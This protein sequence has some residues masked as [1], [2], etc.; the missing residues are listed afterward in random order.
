MRVFSR[1]ALVLG[2]A[3]ISASAALGQ[4]NVAS[5]PVTLVAQ[6]AP[7]T[8]FYKSPHGIFRFGSLVFELRGQ[9]LTT[10]TVTDLGDMQVA[11]EDFV[12]SMAARESNGGTAF[13]NGFLYVSSEAGIEIFDLRGVRPGGNAPLLVSR[14]PNVH[15]RRLAVSGNMLAA[16]FPATDYPCFVNGTA[17]C[18]NVID[19]YNVSNPAAPV[20]VGSISSQFPSQITS[21]NDITFNFGI[22]FATGFNG[23]IGYNLTNPAAAG[24]ITFV[25]TPGT[26]LVSNGTN[27]LGIGSDRQILTYTVI[28]PGTGSFFVLVPLTLHTVAPIDFERANRLV[29][30]PQ[31]NIDEQSLRLVTMIDELDPQTLKPA[32]TI[33]FDV[34]DYGVF[35]YEG[36]LPRV[37][38]QI[39]YLPTNDEVKYNPL[40]VGPLVYVVGELSGLQTYGACG[41]ITGRI[42]FTGINSLACAGAEL[43]GWVTGA[44]KIT[45]VEIFLDGASLGSANITGPPR[46]DVPSTTP[47][48]PWKIAVNLDQTPKGEHV[49]RAVGTDASGNR[50]QFASTRVLFGGPGA[51]CVTRRRAAGLR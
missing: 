11:R 34:F 41:Q 28:Q 42:E 24:V 17:T 50:R 16:L 48:T 23:T 26:F 1:I 14:T 30:H 44:L 51:N 15:Y 45:N 39:S 20:R 5:C 47:V 35:M 6:N 21:F 27:L 31:G 32:R 8:D 4:P 12:G 37:Y 46:I 13:G 29:F 36:S 22:L 9:T 43:H 33:A 49:I 18:F 7:A 38:E 25:E 19:L 10:Y 2:V 3:V 40:S